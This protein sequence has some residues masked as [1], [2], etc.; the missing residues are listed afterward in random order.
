MAATGVGVGSG[1]CLEIPSYVCTGDTQCIAQGVAGACDFQ[2]GICIY[3]NEA[4]PTGNSDAQGNCMPPANQSKGT[5]GNDGNPDQSD[6]SGTDT[7]T[8]F[9]EG[10]DLGAR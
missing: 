2:S 7:D 1:A 10:I 8:E 6:S 9:F 5:A 4:C 3:V